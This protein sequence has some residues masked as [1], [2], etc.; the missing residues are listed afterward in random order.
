MCIPLS[1]I[2][3]SRGRSGGLRLSNDHWTGRDP[4]HDIRSLPWPSDEASERIQRLHGWPAHGFWGPSSSHETRRSRGD[5]HSNTQ[6]ALLSV[7]GR[8]HW[9]MTGFTRWQYVR[10]WQTGSYQWLHI[11]EHLYDSFWNLSKGSIIC[12]FTWQLS[13]VC[14]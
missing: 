2:L 11:A 8:R 6:V 13:V 7:A 5:G 3:S 14:G 1:R 10:F 9:L 12:F 4:Y